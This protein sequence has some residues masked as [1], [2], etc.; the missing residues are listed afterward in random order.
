MIIQNVFVIEVNIYIYYY[1]S[2]LVLNLINFL[3]FIKPFS[4][5]LYIGLIDCD[6]DYRVIKS[7]ELYGSERMFNKNELFTINKQSNVPI[8]ENNKCVIGAY[9]QIYEDEKR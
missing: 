4:K 7:F 2:I 5:S 3:F 8:I 1:N 9:I 6:K